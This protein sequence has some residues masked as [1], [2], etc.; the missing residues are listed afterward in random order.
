M[1]RGDVLLELRLD[2]LALISDLLRLLCERRFLAK[3][4]LQV[5]D[6]DFV[7]LVT[8]LDLDVRL[9]VIGIL[10]LWLFLFR[11][12]LFLSFL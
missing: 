2:R 4:T 1:G 6:R 5:L 7:F 9:V 12:V 8:D 10:A 3:E 11:A